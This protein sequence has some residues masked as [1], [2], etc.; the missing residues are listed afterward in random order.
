LTPE[1]LQELLPLPRAL[2]LFIANG[3]TGI[4]MMLGVPRHH[5]W[6]QSVS[7][8]ELVGL[9][10]RIASGVFDGPKPVWPRSISVS[11]EQEARVAV[12][13][14]RDV[15]ADFIKIYELLPREACFAIADESKKLGIPFVGHVPETILA[16]EAAEAGQKSIEHRNLDERFARFPEMYEGMQRIADQLEESIERGM[17]A[18]EAEE[19]AI[20]Q[21]NKLGK[22]WLRDWAGRNTS[23]V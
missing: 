12:R 6:R 11:N 16:Q 19:I 10:L 4:R 15:G 13:Q 5:E 23:G 9:R 7:A 22:A 14:S 17:S 2:G 21:I 18:D 8:G 3:V 1:T 20:A